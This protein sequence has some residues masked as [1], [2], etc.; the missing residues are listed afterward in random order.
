MNSPSDRPFPRGRASIV[1]LMIV[2]AGLSGCAGTSELPPEEKEAIN[3]GANAEAGPVEVGNLL[4]VT[5]GE[6]EPARLIGVLLNE[7]EASVEVTLSDED[8][9][10]VVAL[11]PGQQYAFQE[12]PTLFDTADARPG[13]LT[14][15]TVSVGSDSETVQVPVRDGT[16]GWLEPYL[17]AAG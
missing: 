9:E 7:S 14:D 5:R 17:P 16:L 10:V 1:S 4:V 3:L 2:A 8:D 12:N 11:E 6:S 13:A 15:I